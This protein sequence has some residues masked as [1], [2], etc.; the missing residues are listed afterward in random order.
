MVSFMVSLVVTALVISGGVWYM[1]RRPA[2]TPT[3]WGEAMVGAFYVFVGFFLIYGVVPH[4]WLQWAD[5]PLAWRPD[6]ILYGPWDILKPKA[7]GGNFPLTISYETLRDLVAVVIY[8]VFL[9]LNVVLW[10]T[11]QKRGQKAAPQP[12][13]EYGRPLVREGV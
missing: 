1:K 2:G 12:V 9:G 8:N 11:W 6:K 7:E 4:Y 5:G 13:S 3:T 10:I